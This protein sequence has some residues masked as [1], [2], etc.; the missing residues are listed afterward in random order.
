MSSLL[1][2]GLPLLLAGA[3]LLGQLPGTVSAE[4]GGR[5]IGSILNCDRPVNPPRC[6]SVGDDRW[7]FVV[8]DP[9]VPDNLAAS[10]RRAMAEVYD[11]TYL[12]VVEQSQVTPVT[13]AI[14]YAADHGQNGAAGWVYCPPD[15]PQGVNLRGDRWC[16]HQQIHFN[17][18]ARYSVFFGDEASR[19][20]LACHELGHTIGLLH[21]GNPPESRGP[22]A[23]TCMNSDTPNGPTDLHDIDRQHI[24]DYYAARDSSTRPMR[25]IAPI[26][27]ATTGPGRQ[28]IGRGFLVFAA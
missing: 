27:E 15:A 26:S 4:H 7:H 20:H 3:L 5:D 12:I 1:R 14:A 8:I 28:A 10:L 6:T 2:R 19:N 11:P 13:D 18:N 16:R 22:T 21:W 9:S 23:A 25:R 17:L 24:L